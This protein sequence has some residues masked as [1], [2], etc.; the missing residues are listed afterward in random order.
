[1]KSDAH[2]HALV[3]EGR[4]LLRL[5]PAA[6]R[7]SPSDPSRQALD[8]LGLF[9]AWKVREPGRL[10]LA[11]LQALR[12][13]SGLRLLTIRLP[14]LTSH[15][16]TRHESALFIKNEPPRQATLPRLCP[17]FGALCPAREDASTQ[18][19]QPTLRYEHPLDRST[20]ESPSSLA[21]ASKA[22]FHYRPQG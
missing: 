14:A 11:R 19:L 8:L 20:P 13:E 7:L 17:P 3:L 18:L 12:P 5:D 22:G 1:V 15:P 6:F 4:A 10:P 21:F 9:K 2:R 16:F